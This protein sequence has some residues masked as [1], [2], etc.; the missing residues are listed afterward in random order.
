MASRIHNSDYRMWGGGAEMWG[1]VSLFSMCILD[2]MQ[3][4][5]TSRVSSA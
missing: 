2:E 5:R 3:W 4:T 1:E